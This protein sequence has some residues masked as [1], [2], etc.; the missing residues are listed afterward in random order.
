MEK[1]IDYLEES[2][3]LIEKLIE[4]CLEDISSGQKLEITRIKYLK[5]LFKKIENYKSYGNKKPKEIKPNIIRVDR[6]PSPISI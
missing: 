2:I 4:D 5:R 6:Y 3:I 1:P